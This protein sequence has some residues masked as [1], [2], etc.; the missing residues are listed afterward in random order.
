MRTSTSP[1]EPENRW[2]T[3][4]TRLAA[5]LAL[6]V[7]FCAAA[8][9]A[10]SRK[11]SAE[12]RLTRDLRSRGFDPAAVVLPFG[13][14]DEMRRWARETAPPRLPAELK[15]D[16]LVSGLLESD[17]LALEYSWGYTGTAREVFE[18]HRA[19]CLAFT[20]L[21][22]AMAREVGVAVYFLGVATETYRK[23]EDFVVVSDHIAVGY[24]AGS[25]I[26][27][28]DF[29]E[30]PGQDYPDVRRISDL[31]AVAMFHS[32]RGTELLQQG[33]ISEALRWLRA[34]AALDPEL[35]TA[36]VNLG[37]A[38]RRSGDLAAA[39]EAYR[40]ALELDPRTYSAYQNLASV[41]RLG[42]RVAEARE[43]ELALTKSPNKNPFT[44]LSLGDIS[45]RSG[46]LEEARKLY[47]RA[48]SLDRRHAESYAALGQLAVVQGDLN[49]ARRML[50]KARRLDD[51]DGRTVKLASM[52]SS[53]WG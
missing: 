19:N 23:Q 53:H 34:A 8:A 25:E 21:F 43:F 39:E 32:N 50:K 16:R 6:A 30:N 4:A 27:M 13:L 38:L 37:V 44:Y 3:F 40:T 22:L 12:E 33:Q 10:R 24:G 11:L 31:T 20:N 9:D 2:T 5:I 18:N 35:A 1:R 42:G 28:F 48:V 7:L 52:I 15:L 17:E 14:S 51:D 41:L 46:R 47:R 26:L 36:W 29:G 49:T 45:F